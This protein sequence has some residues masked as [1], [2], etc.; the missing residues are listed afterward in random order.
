MY[1]EFKDEMLIPSINGE[2]YFQ[3]Y[4]LENWFRR[5]CLTAYMKE[6]GADWITHIPKQ[7]L[8]SFR[9]KFHKSQELL[10]LDIRGDDNLIWLATHSELIQLLLLGEVASQVSLLTG[11]TQTSLSQKLDEL[12]HIRN[13]LAHNRAFSETTLVIVRGIIASLRQGIQYFKEEVLY[14]NNSKILMGKTFPVEDE[15]GF[16]DNELSRYLMARQQKYKAHKLQVF[17]SLYK[18]LYSLVSLP[19]DRE[20][21]YPSAARLL[22]AYQDVLEYI[23][24]FTLNKTGDEY[25]VLI[26]ISISLEAIK[27]VIDKF[28]PEPHIWTNT[29]FEQQNPKYICNPKI[30]FYENRR[31]LEE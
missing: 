23:L 4:E 14:P 20:G 15:N 17:I 29:G 10:H 24:A 1:L 16:F 2:V 9:S 8:N 6:F 26:P 28:I 30:W 13:I 12:K 18:D 3:I 7:I 11:I 27:R 31:P 19:I 25:S 22:D 21:T 5:I